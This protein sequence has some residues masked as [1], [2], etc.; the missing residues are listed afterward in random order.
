MKPLIAALLIAP[1]FLAAPSPAHATCSPQLIA[2]S[3][4]RLPPLPA[5]VSMDDLSCVGV[6]QIY[7]IVTGSRDLRPFQKRQA[8]LA[9]FRREGLIR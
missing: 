5:G 9:V 2:V 8:I 7:F 6:A 4:P 1:F 3:E